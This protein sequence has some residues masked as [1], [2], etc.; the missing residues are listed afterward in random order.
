V[1][2]RLTSS[3]SCRVGARRD[4]G[5]CRFEGRTTR[6]SRCC[7]TVP[8]DTS[9]ALSSYADLAPEEGGVTKTKLR[10]DK[11]SVLKAQCVAIMP[12][13]F[14]R[15]ASQAELTD[16]QQRVIANAVDRSVCMVDDATPATTR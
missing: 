9:G 6:I 13:S 3:H 15:A 2:T 16:K 5:G 14:S 1:A 11:A 8:L 7:A 10:V 4:R 12:T